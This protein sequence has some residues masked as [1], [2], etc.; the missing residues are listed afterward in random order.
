MTEFTGGRPENAP[1]SSVL[2][3]AIREVTGARLVDR[4]INPDLLKDI[5][6]VTLYQ[7][8]GEGVQRWFTLP[9]QALRPDDLSEVNIDTKIQTP[10]SLTNQH[11]RLT[12]DR[13]EMHVEGFQTDEFTQM[14]PY[15][16]DTLARAL[17][18]PENTI[19]ITFITG[20]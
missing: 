14:Q 5:T 1:A 13:L 9:G 18:D 19:S 3:D 11:F 6:E 7:N 17:L 20:K 10:G 15:F 12:G 2:R 4:G 16:T 8:K